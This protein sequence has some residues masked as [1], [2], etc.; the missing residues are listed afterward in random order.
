MPQE[1]KLTDGQVRDIRSSTLS[2]A[3][4]AAKY[5]VDRKTVRNIRHGLTYSDVPDR[6]PVAD[7]FHRT[8]DSNYLVGDPLGLLGRIPAGYVETVLTAPRPYRPVRVGDGE[9]R[10]H[11]RR[12]QDLIGECLRVVG[13][14]GV[15]MYVHRPQFDEVGVADVGD[16]LFQ[17]FPLRQVIVW[18]CPI[19]YERR[20]EVQR[21]RGLRGP[22]NYA[23]ILVFAGEDWRVPAD[24]AN[25]LAR[26]GTVW[27]LRR[28]HPANSPP[29]FSI[30]VAKRC[31]ALGRG[32]VLDPCAG[33]GTTAMAAKDAGRDWII[34]DEVDD[35]LEHF[36]WR[37]AGL[38]ERDPALRSISLGTRMHQNAGTS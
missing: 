22:Q 3:R 13:A 34:G 12:Q 26:W 7:G 32:P 14:A 6:P 15:V 31:I 16:G 37:L 4:M 36:E 38:G 10:H 30:D 9:H 1:R 23:N 2:Q 25:Q 17:A 35:Y 11:I 28:P 33:T 5:G 20:T 18:N 8:V 27:T 29:E 21:P 24:V 19:S